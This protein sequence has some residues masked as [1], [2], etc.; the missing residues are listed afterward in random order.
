MA[1]PPPPRDLHCDLLTYLAKTP[2][3]T[4]EDRAARCSIPQLKKG[5]VGFQVMAVFTEDSKQ[6]YH[7]ARAQARAFRSLM[8]T[9]QKEI[10]LFPFHEEGHL[11]GGGKI[12]AVAA[13]ENAAPLL[14]EGEGRENLEENLDSLEKELGPLFYI[15]LTWNGE[16]R[17]G[18]GAFAEGIGLKEDGQELLRLMSQ[19][20]IAADI[21]HASDALASDIFSFIEK[22]KLT[23][24][25]I[26]SHS[27]TR[28]VHNQARNLPDE[29]IKEVIRGKGL[30]GL[31]FVRHFIDDNRFEKIREHA[32]HILNLGGEEALSFGADFFAAEDLPPE[33]YRLHASWYFDDFDTAESMPG[34]LEAIT[35]GFSADLKKRIAHS[36][37]QAF[38]TRHMHGKR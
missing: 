17:F 35:E 10:A 12:S 26:A 27:N 34:A 18:G 15:S 23:L 7:E 22:E 1:P 21:S 13:L 4:P 11:E 33:R 31:N 9:H 5:K 32:L 2:A 3:R 29:L 14:R 30:I 8:S 6:A 20:G 16:N 25:V 36:N 24:P 28:L 19:R 37:V 38:I